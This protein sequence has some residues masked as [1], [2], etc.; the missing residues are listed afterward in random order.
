MLLSV[1][2]RQALGQALGGLEGEVRLLAFTDRA[3]SWQACPF[4]G[5]TVA[6][7][8]ELAVASD[9]VSLEVHD[10]E[11]EPELAAFYRV[12]AVP[13]LAMVGPDGVDP[14]I[15]FFGIPAGFEL[16]ALLQALAELSSGDPALQ[17]STVEALAGL[18][19]DVVIKVFVT[20]TCPYCPRAL[21]AMQMAMASN[22]VRAEVVEVTEFPE[23]ADRYRVMAVPT[24]VINDSAEA[25]GALPEASFVGAVLD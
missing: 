23:L 1:K 25:A 6:L 13:A 16:A 7:V 20:P 18:H 19:E 3:A 14:G 8:E 12:D 17:P 11:A 22:R 2:D 21:M 4:C 10:V 15:R 24:I 9:K 5:E